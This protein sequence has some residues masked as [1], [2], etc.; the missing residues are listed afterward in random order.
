MLRWSFRNK[1]AI[2]PTLLALTVALCW[3]QRERSFAD[4]KAKLLA[5]Q[6]M[7]MADVKATGSGTV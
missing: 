1:S 4:E 2:L 3:A 6:T 5:S 7:T